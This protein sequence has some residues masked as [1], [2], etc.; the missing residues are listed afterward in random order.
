MPGQ[1]R[2]A[3]TEFFCIEDGQVLKKVKLVF[4]AH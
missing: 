2:L 1:L 4:T 3:D